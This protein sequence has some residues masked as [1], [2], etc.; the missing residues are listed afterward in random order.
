MQKTIFHT[1]K[2]FTATL[3]SLYYNPSEHPVEIQWQ[4]SHQVLSNSGLRFKECTVFR[5]S[6]LSPSD[7]VQGNLGN[8]WFMAA[9]AS[10]AQR[11]D[12][13]DKLFVTK[14]YCSRGV[15]SIRLFIHGKWTTVAIDDMLPCDN[16][17][18]SLFSKIIRKQLW[19]PLVE[20]AVAK[21]FGC[22]ESLWGGHSA[23]GDY[24]IYISFY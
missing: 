16:K 8:C 19:V 7:V 1:D 6:S 17:G 5:R 11:T 20:K 9:L 21:E 3:Q 13:I 14:E 23:E 18:Y 4:R 2:Q 10:L 24:F 12:L 15:F 22:Y